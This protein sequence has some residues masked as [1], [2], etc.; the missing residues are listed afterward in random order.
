MNI[1][2][3][4]EFIIT[5]QPKIPDPK[6]RRRFSVGGLSLHKYIGKRNANKAI[7]KALQSKADKVSLRF[8]KFGRIDFY[9]K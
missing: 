6:G 7:I 1:S 8:R 3:N 2:I 9:R 5:F 4:K